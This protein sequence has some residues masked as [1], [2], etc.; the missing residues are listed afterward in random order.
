M[1]VIAYPPWAWIAARDNHIVAGMFQ[2]IGT[3][4]FDFWIEIVREDLHRLLRR[5][6]HLSD[7]ARR[8]CARPRA[9]EVWLAGTMYHPGLAEPLGAAGLR[10]LDD[11]LS[12]AARDPRPRARRARA[13]ERQLDELAHA[14]ARQPR[15]HAAADRAAPADRRRD[16]RGGVRRLLVP[17]QFQ[18]RAQRAVRHAVRVRGELGTVR[19]PDVPADGRDRGQIPASARR[20]SAPPTRGSAR[21]PA[22]SRS[23]PTGPAPASAP[24]P[25]RASRRPP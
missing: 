17:A 21:C 12:R 22:G 15:H 8:R 1:V 25:D 23:R 18:R 20:C 19:D 5:G 16:G 11:A 9:G 24:R 13:G 4:R 6:V 10:R 7:L 2:D 3:P 14:V